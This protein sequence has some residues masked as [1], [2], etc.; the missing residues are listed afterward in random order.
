MK[1]LI[2]ILVYLGSMV[3]FYVLMSCI[4]LLWM[5]WHDIMASDGWR[6]VYFAFIGW[7]L[8]AFPAMDYYK[9]N[10]EWLDKV[11]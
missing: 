1:T 5:S 2:L 6:I 9:Q 10:E 4:G 8:A 3:L 7:W 11:F